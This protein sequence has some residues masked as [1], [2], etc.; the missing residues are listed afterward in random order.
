MLQDAINMQGEK[1]T[2]K[3]CRKGED[4]WMPFNEPGYQI[5]ELDG[6]AVPNVAN[7]IQVPC[8]EVDLKD[9]YSSL[10][11][12]KTYMGQDAI[13]WWNDT[14][15]NFRTEQESL[16]QDCL[17]FR[18]ILR[19]NASCGTDS[20][21]VSREKASLHSKAYLDLFK[22][23]SANENGTHPKWVGSPFPSPEWTWNIQ[24]GYNRVGRDA[25]HQESEENAEDQ[26]SLALAGVAL[27]LTSKMV[28]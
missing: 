27:R 8:S 17:G 1:Y 11:I 3:N 12:Y 24:A 23:L 13:Q 21:E 2:S 14:L 22:H 20:K 16:C 10:E 5:L 28:Q 19:L 7:L 15:E 6:A 4:C 25:S 18:K 9:L 26:N